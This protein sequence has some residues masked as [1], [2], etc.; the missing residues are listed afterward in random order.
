MIDMLVLRCNFKKEA[1]PFKLGELQY[2]TFK[3]DELGIPL[4]KFF[5]KD[6]D[7]MNVRHPWESIPSSFEGIAFKVFD[8]RFN[9]LESFYIEIKASPAKLAQGHNIFGSSDFC[10]CALRLIFVLCHKYPVLANK[11]DFTTW[12]LA[13]IDITYSSRAK[14]E[15]QAVAFINALSNVSYGQ[16]K[17]RDGCNGTAYFGK[18]NSRL[19]KIKVYAKHSE[20][21]QTIEKKKKQKPKE[22]DFV[23]S[24]ELLEFSKGLIRW[25]VSFFHRHFERMGLSCY[26]T[27]IFQ[28]GSFSPDYLR[29]FWKTGFQDLFKSTKGHQMKVVN[30]DEILK[31]LRSEFFKTSPKTGLTS[32]AFA[33]SAYRTYRSICRDGWSNV[34]D[35]MAKN[36]FND[37]VRM[38]CKCG[39]ARAALQNMNGI[40]D[41]S[42]FLNFS[43][44]T[45]IDF[46]AQF[47]DW[48]KQEPPKY[49]LQ[50]LH[51]FVF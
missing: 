46:D 24:P 26:L 50:D 18:K 39:L 5:D 10:D 28:S 7:M 17:S 22:N 44:F 1:N 14:T 51:E 16:T 12:F 35:L 42:E 9:A 33:D 15:K 49:T 40:D 38:I 2:P 31:A 3:L 25:E 19:K 23:F 36:T 34:K 41:S 13:Q 30:D 43:E 20:V 27:D 37:H 32:T 11:L 8:N 4:E 29:C 47:P 45:Q 6:G 48:Y 21:L